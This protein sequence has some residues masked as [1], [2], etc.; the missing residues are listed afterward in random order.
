M[1]D[2]YFVI[3]AGGQGQRLWPLS[4]KNNPKPLIPFLGKTSLLEQTIN[5]IES[6]T[7]SNK[8]IIIITA[9]EQ[10]DSVKNLVGD[11][12]GQIISEPVGRNTAPAILLSCLK[13]KEENENAVVVVLSADHF[14]PETEK[15]QQYLNSAIDFASENNELAIFGLKPR[16]AATGYGY[17]QADLDK[18]IENFE[19]YK[20]L[21][22]HEKPNQDVADLYIECC[23]MFWNVGI[24]VSNLKTFLNE[25]EKHHPELVNNMQ[26]YLKTGNDYENLKSISIDYAVMEK[27]ENVVV[28]PA[29]FEWY[30]I[31][32][33]DVFLT[34]QQK[35]Y[36]KQK[37]V[38]DI[39]SQ[40]NLVKTKKLAVLID[41]E[42]LCV[43]ETDEVVLISKR[44]KVE[45]VKNVVGIL[46]EKKL[47]ELL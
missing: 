29:D 26:S 2:I 35:H 25:F 23:Y 4:R 46:N 44:D 32:N 14:I 5:R 28:F 12:V 19:S 40:N 17:I 15:F 38:I 36:Q 16:Y 47:R 8:N 6:L 18:K 24:F 3:L 9:L 7:Q 10:L 43:V 1:K 34:L 22:F 21:K 30:D 41:V 39:D 45:K 13:I 37:N 31:G 11:K 42:D 33:L 20:V 27:S